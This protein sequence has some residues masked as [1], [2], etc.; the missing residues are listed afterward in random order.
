MLGGL[1]APQSPVGP[2]HQPG[3]EA[4]VQVLGQRVP[5]SPRRPRAQWWL[6]GLRARH[7]RAVREALRQPRRRDA[8][9]LAEGEQM[10]VVGLE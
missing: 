10:A 2:L 9:Q 3:E 6:D 1:L 8:G 7:Q 4:G 5:S